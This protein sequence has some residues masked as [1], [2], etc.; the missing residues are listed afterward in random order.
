MLLYVFIVFLIFMLVMSYLLAEKDKMA[1]PVVLCFGFLLAAIMCVSYMD[2]WYFDL[3]EETFA[4]L[5]LG[6]SS[7]LLGYFLLAKKSNIGSR[8]NVVLPSIDITWNKTILFI[9]VQLFVIYESYEYINIIATLF[10]MT[11]NLAM[12]IVAYRLSVVSNNGTLDIPPIPKLLAYPR[13]FAYMGGLLFVYKLA[14]DRYKFKIW[15]MKCIIVCL[16]TLVLAL[17]EGSRGAVLIHIVIPYIIFYYIMTMRQKRWRGNIIRV[18]RIL[19]LIVAAFLGMII[20]FSSLTLVGRGDDIEFNSLGEVVEASTEQLSIYMGAELKLLDIYISEEYNP[21]KNNFIGEKT[22][23]GVWGWLNNKLDRNTIKDD[24]GFRTVNG[25]FLGNVYTM[26]KPYYADGGFVGVIIFSF[27]MGAFFSY[28][29]SRVRLCIDYN[30]YGIDVCV[31]IYGYIY[32]T[33]L[34]S[35]FSNWFYNEFSIVILQNL[36]SYYVITRCFFLKN[37]N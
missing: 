15:N 30:I 8:E 36:L 19:K 1:A 21:S 12:K 4:V 37:H 16:G 7:F 5:V 27:I 20:F 29:Y 13:T 14:I 2:K 28:V 32:Y 31:L 22:L 26:F 9:L 6:I 17:M 35:F 33:V 24:F 23:S 18:K 3:H 11:D 34:L 10:G 25:I